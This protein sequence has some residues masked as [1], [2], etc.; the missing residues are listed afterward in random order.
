MPFYGSELFQLG[1]PP[2]ASFIA[3]FL[4]CL[5]TLHLGA[6][7]H[8][9]P[10]ASAAAALLLS[11][12]LIVTRTASLVPS[13]FFSS[14]YGGSFVG[15]TPAALLNASILRTG[16]SLDSTFILLSLFCGS[17]FCLA[18]ALD[19]WLRGGLARGYGGRLGALAALASFLFIGLAPSFG[20]D[21]HL[22]PM[23]GKGLLEQGSGAAALTFVQCAAGIMATMAALRWA[24]VAGSARAVRIAVAAA[25][26]FVG[27][28]ALQ[29]IV[30]SGTCDL[31]A[32]YAGC[33]VG[34]SSPRRLRGIVQAMAVAAVLTVMLMMT[35]P[36]LPVVGGSLGYV[37][38]VSVIFVDAAFLLFVEAGETPRH[39]LVA[40]TRGLIA[41][42]AIL[43]V[44]LP[45][46]LLIE[47]QAGVA[48][49]HAAAAPVPNR[50]PGPRPLQPD[51]GRTLSDASSAAEASYDL[52]M[53]IL[54]PERREPSNL[55]AEDAAEPAPVLPGERQ[56]EPQHV[57]RHGQAAVQPIHPAVVKRNQLRVVPP[58]TAR[59]RVVARQD[60]SLLQAWRP[61]PSTAAGP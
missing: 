49:G 41:A 2:L 24:P 59:P 60:A 18:C 42:L 6:T 1:C 51:A 11:A 57:T 43:A 54:Q 19:M 8:A 3:A 10:I 25:V 33:F 46:E 15:M 30:G 27:L 44:M 34:M 61:D 22:F 14:A 53:L 4:G 58:A 26:A 48:A 37:A 45:S 13:T 28:L 31:E 9:P 56:P 5:M 36:I 55:Q 32:Y 47:Q 50:P 38:F 52:P 16:L 12:S 23:A 21:I 40:A 17:V 29:H 39:T 7:G 35:C 20:T